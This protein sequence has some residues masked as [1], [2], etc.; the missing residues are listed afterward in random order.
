VRV[1]FVGSTSK[2]LHPTARSNKTRFPHVTPS[3]ALRG[4]K[5]DFIDRDDPVGGQVVRK[6]SARTGGRETTLLIRLPIGAFKPTG[7]GTHVAQPD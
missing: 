4:L 2:R 7:L 6:I 5:I 1:W 3:G